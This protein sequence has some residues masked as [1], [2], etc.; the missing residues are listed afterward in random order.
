[1]TETSLLAIGLH[2]VAAV[3]L[4]V[5]WHEATHALA[6]WTLG[7]TVTDISV[8]GRRTTVRYRDGA[9]AWHHHAVVQAPMVVGVLVGGLLLAAGYRP[10]THAIGLI[11]ALAWVL[12]SVSPD[13]LRQTWGD[14]GEE[15]EHHKERKRALGRV[16]RVLS[17]GA[18]GI[19]AATAV[20]GVIGDAVRAGTL[21]YSVPR[22]IR[23]LELLAESSEQFSDQ[24]ATTETETQNQAHATGSD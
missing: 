20:A 8:S 11:W 24:T 12:F 23:A 13:D 17:T 15:P 16:G 1:M 2:S 5:L 6:A 19:G 18:I 4:A 14:D 7:H 10:A 3:F 9:P 21:A 22:L